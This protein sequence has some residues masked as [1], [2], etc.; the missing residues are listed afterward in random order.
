MDNTIKY[1]V[2]VRSRG[3]NPYGAN[4]NVPCKNAIF[5][6]REEA[7]AYCDSGT[8]SAFNSYYVKEI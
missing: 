6:T 3:A 8:S 5:S 4:L 7:Q 1:Q 2:W